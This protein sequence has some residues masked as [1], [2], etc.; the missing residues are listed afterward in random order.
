MV[1]AEVRHLG[2]R[3]QAQRAVFALV[4]RRDDPL[5]DRDMGR[6][7]GAR[8]SLASALQSAI[9]DWILRQKTGPQ[10]L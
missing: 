6:R 3:G 5:D 10:P 9:H 2:H 4:H 7:D 1:G 8:R